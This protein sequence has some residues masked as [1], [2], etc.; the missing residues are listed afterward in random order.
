MPSPTRLVH[1][2]IKSGNRAK[3]LVYTIPAGRKARENYANE[4]AI[5]YYSLAR[6]ILEELGMQGTPPWVECL[7][8]IGE[9]YLLIGKSEDA[10]EI[11]TSLLEYKNTPVEQ[12]LVYKNITEAYFKKGEFDKCEENGWKGLLLLNEKIPTKN[13]EVWCGYY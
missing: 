9:V 13:I 7:E 4:E 2:T 6:D 12:A 3:A 10:I 1:H 8:G 11:F 5:R